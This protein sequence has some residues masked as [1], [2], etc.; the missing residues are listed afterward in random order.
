MSFYLTFAVPSR[1]SNCNRSTKRL[2]RFFD[3]C[4]KRLIEVLR[5]VGGNDHNSLRSLGQSFQDR[6]MTPSCFLLSN[7]RASTKK[8]QN[9][10]H[11]GTVGASSTSALGPFNYVSSFSAQYIPATIPVVQW[12]H[13]SYFG[14]QANLRLFDVFPIGITIV[15]DE[16]E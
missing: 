6:I 16:E 1:A 3:C 11:D 14:G 10:E 2:N 13:S 7:H 5:V 8:A 9:H 4:N 15:I 12:R